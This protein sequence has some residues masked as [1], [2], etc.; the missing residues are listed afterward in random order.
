MKQIGNRKREHSRG[1]SIKETNNQKLHLLIKR[2]HRLTG[3]DALNMQIRI[4]RLSLTILRANIAER[5]RKHQN[6]V[7]AL[8]KLAEKERLLADLRS[9]K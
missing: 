2:V 8:D 5:K 1:Q 4:T 6:P 9:R 7:D 3:R